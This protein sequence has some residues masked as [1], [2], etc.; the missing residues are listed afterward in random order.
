MK[1]NWKERVKQKTESRLIGWAWRGPQDTLQREVQSYESGETKGIREDKILE[2]ITSWVSLEIK[3]VHAHV[4]ERWEGRIDVQWR[5][6]KTGKDEH[7]KAKERLEGKGRRQK[8]V[9]SRANRE[10]PN[11]QW[12]GRFIK[13]RRGTNGR[14]TNLTTSTVQ[15]MEETKKK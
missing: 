1:G 3:T 4:L 5:G 15:E 8:T 7:S 14:A 13:G 12:E 11:Q 2:Q 9:W 6:I 10:D